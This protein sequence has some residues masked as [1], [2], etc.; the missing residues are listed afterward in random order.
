[1]AREST[2]PAE[3]FTPREQAK[4]SLAVAQIKDLLAVLSKLLD[5]IENDLR[6]VAFAGRL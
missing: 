5:P 3:V 4:L 2:M 1:M 6:D